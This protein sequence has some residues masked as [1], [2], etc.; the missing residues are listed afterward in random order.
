MKKICCL[1]CP[2]SNNI[3]FL[4]FLFLSF[5][6][7]SQGWTFYNTS[8]SPLPTNDIR[9]IAIDASGNKWIGMSNTP[10][11]ALAKFDGTNWTIFDNTN[12]PLPNTG[13]V[14]ALAC[15]GN[16][17]WVGTTGGIFRFDGTNWITYTMFN[18]GLPENFVFSVTVAPTGEKW[19]STY[20][21]GVAVFDDINW[22]IYDT[23]NSSIPSN[24]IRKVIIQDP[25]NIWIGTQGGL[26]KFDGVSNWT[27]YNNGN[28]PLC[29]TTSQVEA[30]DSNGYRWGYSYTIMPDTLCV[31]KF[32]DTSWTTYNSTNSNYLNPSV[33]APYSSGILAIDQN[34]NK[35]VGANNGVLKFNDTSWVLYDSTIF[36]TSSPYIKTIAVD[37]NNCVWMGGWYLGLAVYCG[38]SGVSETP[39]EVSILNFYPNPFHDFAYLKISKTFF[40]N[41]NRYDFIIYDLTGRVI[42]SFSLKER[43]TK[44]ERDNMISGIY[45]YNLISPDNSILYSGKIIIN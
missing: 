5:T 37:S 44:I 43:I 40:N 17:I 24:Y 33:I 41:K 1:Y 2:S 42:K 28:S 11:P 7:F 9:A 29:G 20:S 6:T 12:S 8:N 23:S 14:S 31:M 38:L 18:S 36:G 4:F 22:T 25:N 35:W 30:I 3:F 16:I 15:E 10:N 45:L 39:K 21:S 26:A 32:T 19:I 34:N 27:I 13:Y